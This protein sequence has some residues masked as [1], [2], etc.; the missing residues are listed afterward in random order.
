MVPRRECAG[1][2]ADPFRERGKQG[3]LARA[4]ALGKQGGGDLGRGPHFV[5]SVFQPLFWGAWSLKGGTVQ[6]HRDM[7]SRASIE[8]PRFIDAGFHLPGGP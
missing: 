8:G 1:K 3:H 7:R 4:S 2:S 6:P 5:V